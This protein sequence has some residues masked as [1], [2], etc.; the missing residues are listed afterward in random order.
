MQTFLPFEDFRECAKVL[1]NKRLY[2]QILEAR[3]ILDTLQGKS[4][5][6]INH[7]IVKM[8]KGYEDALRVYMS[9]MFDEWAQRRWGEYIYVESDANVPPMH[10]FPRWLGDKELH[11][12]HRSNLLR[13]SEEH[14]SQYFEK[15]LPNDIPY[16]WVME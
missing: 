8:W 10:S 3:Q 2:K 11:K 7:P 6:W 9:F 1:D 13:K 12:S 15:D 16:K 4:K 14:Y 5:G